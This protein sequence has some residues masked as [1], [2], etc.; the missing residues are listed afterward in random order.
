MGHALH[1]AKALRRLW[2][3][4]G[5]VGTCNAIGDAGLAALA[6]CLREGA[7]P[8]LAQIDLNNNGIGDAGVAA[9]AAC[10]REGAA[11]KLEKVGLTDGNP[12]SAA[13]VQALQQAREGLAVYPALH[14]WGLF[15]D[16][17]SVAVGKG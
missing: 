14:I 5:K 16:G 9:L 13:A 6:A 12:V 10:L 4:R 3:G 11:P 2:L 8:E 17:S 15:S 1:E 7:A